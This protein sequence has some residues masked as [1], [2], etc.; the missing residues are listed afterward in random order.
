MLIDT[1]EKAVD[2]VEKHTPHLKALSATPLSGGYV[3]YVYRLVCQGG[4]TAILK[5]Y[6]PFIASNTSKEFSPD[7]FFVELAALKLSH[8]CSGF[9]WARMPQ[10]LMADA[11]AHC[12]VME[13]AGDTLEPLLDC[14]TRSS[15]T[16]ELSPQQLSAD[17][18]ELTA[19][20]LAAELHNFLSAISQHGDDPVFENPPAWALLKEYFNS[21]P[22]VAAKH[23]VPELSTW[24][25][26][27]PP[28]EPPDPQVKTLILGDLWPNTIHLN[29]TTKTIWLLD[30]E[31]ARRGAIQRDADQLLDNL[32]IMLQNPTKYRFD[33]TQQLM[34]SLQQQY[35]RGSS[36]GTTTTGIGNSSSSSRDWRIGRGP[37]FVR[38]IGM[39]TQFP[40]WELQDV[41]AVMK[42]AIQEVE[43][44]QP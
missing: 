18:P 28:F 21:Y 6:P 43:G 19:D 14:L 17:W 38:S 40:H 8:V 25:E 16:C 11:A 37:E 12:I 34:Q 39:L 35:Y 30:W 42:K 13:D 5:H 15:A 2:F 7:R 44:L 23:N 20:A 29:P 3:N 24:V 22:D 4:K 32:W 36:S 41:G 33:A 10:V 27:A 9:A 26:Q 1:P 31:V